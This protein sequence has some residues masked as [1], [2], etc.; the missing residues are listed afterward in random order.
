MSC[1]PEN[2][3]LMITRDDTKIMILQNLPTLLPHIL[4]KSSKYGILQ[5]DIRNCSSMT[6]PVRKVVIPVAG[7]GTRF[8]PAT[9]A[10]PKEMLP[11]V[12]KPVVQYIVEEAKKSG[13]EQIIF[14]TS[15]NKRAIEDHFD[16]SLE[17][18]NLL[19]KKGKTKELAEIQS[20]STGISYAYVRQGEQKGLGHAVLSARELVGDEPFIVCGGDDII[21]G[22][23]PSIKQLIDVYNKYQDPVLA[24]F[25]VNK[26]E[27]DK[28]GVIDPQAEI[29]KG[30]FEL[31]GI[32]EKPSPEKAPSNY[33]S[34]ARWL[35]TPDIFDTLMQTK[36]GIGGEIQL[37]DGI[38]TLM[39]SRPIYA[40]AVEGTYF[41]CG[42]KI[43][44][45]KAVVHFSLLR[46]DLKD[47]FKAFLKD[48]MC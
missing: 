26:N 12:D 11:I 16:R 1:H 45:L 40:K 37:P 29:S 46:N 36:P 42:N 30:L 44:Y 10:S 28:Y 6:K 7:F 35:L 32:V 14:V 23:S 24:V 31:K 33:I 18:E 2:H 4:E 8:L 41:D 27:V 15:S 39:K 5:I 25:E 17:L 3:F 43:E 38:L 22:K 21:T 13:I 20:I 9:K 19:E 47:A 34:A 48:K